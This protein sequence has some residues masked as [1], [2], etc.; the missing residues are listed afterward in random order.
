[1]YPTK[2][3]S[4]VWWPSTQFQ[5]KIEGKVKSKRKEE[6]N[7]WN[8]ELEMEM[9]EVVQVVK[10]KDIEDYDRLGNMAMKVNKILAIAGPLMT[11]IATG[12]KVV[13][14]MR[15]YVVEVFGCLMG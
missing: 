11:G 5:K 3:E 10:R 12:A 4:E 13:L 7:G 9:E 6:N 2:F 15:E 8:N 14:W 1:M